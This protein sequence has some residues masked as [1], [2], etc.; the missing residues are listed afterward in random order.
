MLD[1]GEMTVPYFLEC[2]L[3]VNYINSVIHGSFYFI[4]QTFLPEFNFVDAFAVD[5]GRKRTV[6]SVHERDA[7]IM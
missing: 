4:D 3:C 1:I 7:F 2:L 5:L 6:I